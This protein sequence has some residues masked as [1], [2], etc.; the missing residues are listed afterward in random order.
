MRELMTLWE[1][2]LGALPS[3]QQFV[4]WA[5]SHAEDIVRK[6]IL[7]TATKNQMLDG[8]M[9]QDH[10]VRGASKVMTT[11]TQQTETNAANRARLR[12]EFEGRS[13]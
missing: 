12:E 3:E 5:E 7:K 10:K 4:I 13:A 1:R 11:L 9:T 2:T 8:T 6:A